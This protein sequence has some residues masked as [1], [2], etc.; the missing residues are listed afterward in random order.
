ME[1]LK[2]LTGLFNQLSPEHVLDAVETGNCRCT[3]RFIILN[4]YENRVYQMELDDDSWV[5]GKFY[6]PGRWSKET[7]EAEHSFLFEL[8]AEEIPAVCPLELDSGGTIGEVSGIMF[9][10]FPRVGGRSPDEPSDDQL[11]ILGRLLGR[12]HN[13]GAARKTPHRLNLTPEVYGTN[14]LNYL[15][16]NDFLPDEARENYV[17]T[18]KQI[19]EHITPLFQD[20]PVH[21]VHGDCH[22]GNLLWGA[23]GPAFLDFDDMVTGPA[24]QDVWMMIPSYD[25]YGKRQRELFLEAY[26]QFRDFDPAWLHLIEPLR[27]LRFIHYSTW[28]AKRWTDPIFKKTFNHFG[29]LQYWQREIQDLREQLGRI[30]TLIWG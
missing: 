26:S 19:I 2:S 20:V 23:D 17:Q 6:R 25:D 21:R 1:E 12:I 5:V 29:T 4:S 10:I 27:A 16:E 14:N 30:T 11:A 8:E 7:I 22:Q 3:G 13:V 28:I 18:V 9:S 24:V 15:L